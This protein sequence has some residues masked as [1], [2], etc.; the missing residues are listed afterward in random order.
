MSE[1]SAYTDGISDAVPGRHTAATTD[2]VRRFYERIQFPGVRPLEQDSLIFLRKFQRLVQA[3]NDARPM[4]I[5]DAG[6]G[7]GN[8]TV[9][10]AA[11]YPSHQFTGIDLSDASLARARQA[12]RERALDNVRFMQWNMLAPMDGDPFDVV[13]CF[14]SLHHTVD[15]CAALQT[16]AGEMTHEGT[17]F[18]WVYGSHGRHRHALNMELLAMLRDAASC[19]DDVAL[20]RL[21]I[22]QV[23]DRMAARDL[24]GERSTDPLL[25]R[26]FDDDTWIADQFLHPNERTVH[27]RDL[28]GLAGAS[29]LRI[30][31]WIGEPRHLETIVRAA[32]L[33]RRFELLGDNERRIALDLLLKP[34]R[35]F[36]VL[37]HAASTEGG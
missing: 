37:E 6:C 17:L 12:A 22:E 32:E 19:D 9:A 21:F 3:W 10:V 2:I 4:R 34:D 27:M 14:G 29:G 20:A 5:L 13:F 30:R 1:T 24:L 31:E 23:G 33:Q 8:T 15:M 18:L 36:L 7:T 11:Q 35:Y 26:F 16:L 28:L 25:H